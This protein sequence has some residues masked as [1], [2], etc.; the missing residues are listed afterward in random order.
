[1]GTR[2]STNIVDHSGDTPFTL[3]RLYIQFDGYPTGVGKD[4][5][6]I[7][8]GKVMVNGYNDE[9]TQ[10]NGAGCMTAMLIAGLKKKC[11]NVYVTNPQVE[12]RE[13]HHYVVTAKG[14]G[15][16]IQIQV[17][18]YDTEVY[19]GPLEDFDPE[20][21]EAAANAAEEATYA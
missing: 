4:I 17:F 1:M 8:A 9:K 11:G 15:K 10:I 19:N 12:E 7:F 20:K 5:K 3:A 14:A 2:S 6:E 16:P 13:G 21:A 18:V